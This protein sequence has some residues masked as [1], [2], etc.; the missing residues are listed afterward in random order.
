MDSKKL[1]ATNGYVL[2]GPTFTR[3]PS[4][5]D[6][7]VQKWAIGCKAFHKE[8]SLDGSTNEMLYLWS[9]QRSIDCCASNGD[10]FYILSLE[11]LY[12]PHPTHITSLS[13][14]TLS[15]PVCEFVTRSLSYGYMRIPTN[16]LDRLSRHITI[17]IYIFWQA[18]G[19]NGQSRNVNQIS[20]G[21]YF[22][23]TEP[24]RPSAAER[25]RPYR[26]RSTPP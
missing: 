1:C 13:N 8:W 18:R 2:Y 20:L 24:A 11:R 4:C 9:H 6:T 14:S 16:I 22:G 17:N 15:S 19:V 23:G 26:P 10:G 3:C 7:G 21:A 12:H 25:L 5:S